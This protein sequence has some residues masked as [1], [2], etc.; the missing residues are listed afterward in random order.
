MALVDYCGFRLIAMSILPISRQTIVYGSNDYGQTVHSS[1]APQ[2]V[3]S[4]KRL[5]QH[6]NLKP[7]YCGTPKSKPVKVYT[8]CDLEGHESHDHRFYLLDYS[9]MMPPETPRPGGVRTAHLFRLLRPEFVR[10]YVNPLCSDGYSSFIRHH[11]ALPLNKEIA[12]ATAV[13]QSELIP[14]FAPEFTSSLVAEVEAHGWRAMETF[15]SSE[16]LHRRGI[17]IRYLGLLRKHTHNSDVRTF[18]LIEIFARVAKNLL[19]YLLREKMKSLR[20]PLEE[21]YRKL[22]IDYLNLLFGD[23]DRSDVYWN[24][25]IRKNVQAHFHDALSAEE[26]QEE[27]FLKPTLTYF[28]GESTD[29][30]YLLLMRIAAMSGLQLSAALLNDLQERP[31]AWAPRGNE[32]FDDVDLVSI[33]ART[34]HMG[35]INQTIG[36]NYLMRATAKYGTDLAAAERL[37]KLALARFQEALD[38]DVR[39]PD[40]LCNIGIVSM[41]LLELQGDLKTLDESD[42]Q[43]VQIQSYFLRAESESTS[44]DGRIRSKVAVSYGNFLETSNRFREAEEYYLRALEADPSNDQALLDY[45]NMLQS[46]GEFA[47]AEQLFSRMTNRMNE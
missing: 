30:K 17:N 5:A 35:I 10:S 18:L 9:R 36:W 34:K 44:M 22:I 7:H 6:L 37:L 47:F 19:R 1:A 28:S 40:V 39:N 20:L 46:R 14:Q 16:A 33:N 24:T 45:G 42:I 12:R 26:C 27:F 25:V 11:N 38:T 2:R 23:S 4:L 15:R 8:P 3:A 21:P 13:L 41:R 31:N 43:V 29:G 32:P